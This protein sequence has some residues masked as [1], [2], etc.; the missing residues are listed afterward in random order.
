VRAEVAAQVGPYRACNCSIEER[1][2]ALLLA[3]LAEVGPLYALEKDGGLKPGDPRGIAFATARLAAGATAVRDMI[4]EAWQQS[5]D[6]PVGYPMVNLRD[7][8]SGKVKVT[9]DLFGAD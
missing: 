1:T 2:R 4:V 3:S 6:T 5:A 8:E 9:R 7:I